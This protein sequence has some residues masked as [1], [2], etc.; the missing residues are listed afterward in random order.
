MNGSRTPGPKSD[1]LVTDG[2]QWLKDLEG[3]AVAVTGTIQL[4]KG[5]PEI[6]LSAKEDVKPA[7]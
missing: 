2:P 7:N 3:K 6:V 5:K 4:Y 1:G